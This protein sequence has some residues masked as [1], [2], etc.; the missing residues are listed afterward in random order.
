MAVLV[1]LEILRPA[2]C[3]MA[4]LAAVTGLAIARSLD[5]P[6]AAAIF[7]AVFLVTGAGNAVNDYYDREIDAVNRPLRPIPSG[8]ISPRGALIL[9]AA[10]FAVSCLLAWQM[11][12]LCLAIAVLN[13]I[14]LFFYARDLKGMPV[15]GN[16]CVSYLT[17]STFLFGGAALGP[18]GAVAN[19]FPAGLSFLGTMS[20]E[21]VKDIEDV[22]GD[23]LGGARTLPILAGREISSAAAAAFSLLAVILSLLA[24]FGT[25]YLVIIAVADLFFLF[26]ML[27]IARG[28]ARGSQR[29]LKLGMAL[30]LLAFLAAALMAQLRL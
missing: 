26:S 11:S 10:L 28:D 22:E 3:L 9:S 8:R 18:L 16:L 4:G 15:A 5:P 25:A 24:P 17:G 7:L 19:L 13:S 30:A 2:N 23:R 12:R 21:I 29:A 6:I 20:R 27:K 14:L 1:I